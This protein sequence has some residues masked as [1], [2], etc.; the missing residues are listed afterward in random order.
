MPI[1]NTRRGQMFSDIFPFEMTSFAFLSQYRDTKATFYLFYKITKVFSSCRDVIH[2]SLL[3]Y[4][5]S[6][7]YQN[8]RRTR[9]TVFYKF[10]WNVMIA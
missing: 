9:I 6:S 5:M 3:Q 2:V 10:I 8:V 1:E 4:K 7:S